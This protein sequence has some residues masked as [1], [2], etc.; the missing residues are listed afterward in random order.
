MRRAWK[1]VLLFARLVA[2]VSENHFDVVLEELI[3]RSVGKLLKTDAFDASAFE[4]LEVHIWQKAEGLRNE[5]MLS[6][7]ILLNLRSAVGAIRSRAEYPPVV[8]ENLQRA[9]DFDMMLD[10]LIGSETRSD[11]KQ[12]MPHII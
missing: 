5:S 12:G 10:Q 2:G 3:D 8:R 11:R 7:Q 1:G 6:K 4:A 9:H